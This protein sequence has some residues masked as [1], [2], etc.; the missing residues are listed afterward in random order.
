[1]KKAFTLVEILV[2]L[3]IIAVLAAIITS[4]ALYALRA[5]K[6]SACSNN[7]N[8]LFTAAQ[9]Y[10]SD[11]DGGFPIYSVGWAKAG[12]NQDIQL[13]GLLSK[14]GATKKLYRCP[15][16][17]L[18]GT[19]A[20]DSIAGGTHLNSS[21]MSGWLASSGTPSTDIVPTRVS[22]LTNPSGFCALEDSF[23]PDHLMIE[24]QELETSH[25][26]RRNVVYFDG[27]IKSEEAAGGYD[28]FDPRVF[29]FVRKQRGGGRGGAFDREP[30]N[31]VLGAG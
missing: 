16:D 25:G 6:I 22:D 1:M 15:L 23:I 29:R 30:S 13:I 28:C 12:S 2:V 21:Y 27:H 7:L 10:A 20:L 14:Y 4:A 9:L 5:S 11:N 24:R 31:Q 26:T 17:S 3:G 18:F 19:K 8:Q